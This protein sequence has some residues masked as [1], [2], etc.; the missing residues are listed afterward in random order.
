MTAKICLTSRNDLVLQQKIK[1]RSQSDMQEK[2][3]RTGNNLIQAIK[4]AEHH[5]KS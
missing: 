3:E 5:K 4:K 2:K 1:E